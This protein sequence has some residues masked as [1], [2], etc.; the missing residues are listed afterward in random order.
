MKILSFIESCCSNPTLSF[1]RALFITL[2]CVFHERKKVTLVGN[3]M[4]VSK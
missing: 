2:Y 4:K 1:C 3:D